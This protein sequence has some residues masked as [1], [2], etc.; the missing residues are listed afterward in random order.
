MTTSIRARGSWRWFAAWLL[1]GCGYAFALLGALS[2]GL[3]I[4]PFA[5][6]ATALLLRRPIA[7]SG[8]PGV[9]GGV[10]VAALFVAYR[11]RNGPGNVCTHTATSV[12]CSQQW[13]PWPWLIAGLL[14]IA[15]AIGWF[16]AR[17]KD[18]AGAR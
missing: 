10:A 11:N 9:L 12:S 6:I 4:L 3:F 18:A 17:R 8:V 13:S 2:I 1:V 14:L 15:L 5:L 7:M 16:V